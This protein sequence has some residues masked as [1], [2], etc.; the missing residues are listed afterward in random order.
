MRF[1]AVAASLLVAHLLTLLL[2]RAWGRPLPWD[3]PPL[4]WGVM[5]LGLLA[6]GLGWFAYRRYVDARTLAQETRRESEPD[7]PS[8]VGMRQR[9]RFQ[10][11]LLDSV[12]ESLIATDLEGTI[13]YWGRGAAGLYGHAAD[14]TLGRSINM[15]LPPEEEGGDHRRMRDALERGVWKGEY[16]QRRKDGTRFWADTTIS[17]VT[18]DRGVPIGLVGIDR[19]VTRRKLAEGA[20]LESEWF[21]RSSLDMLSASVAILDDSATIVAVNA[22][23]RRFAEERGL[24][25]EGYGL[26]GNYLEVCRSAFGV[27]TARSAAKAITGLLDGR[28]DDFRTEYAQRAADGSGSFGLTVTRYEAG[29]KVWLVASHDDLAHT[30]A[31][32]PRGQVSS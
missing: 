13:V 22:A 5:P 9:L 14:E 17:R 32:W 30:Q 6:G 26:G 16:V 19:D 15:I 31:V 3:A 12:R 27:E 23:W 28:R 20:L 8:A 1:A 10:A 7:D 21:L 2:A 29:N 18:D 4:A 25:V 11:Q 24:D